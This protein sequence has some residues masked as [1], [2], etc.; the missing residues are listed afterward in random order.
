MHYCCHVSCIGYR[1]TCGSFVIC[2]M[3]LCVY[4]YVYIYMSIYILI[5]RSTH[6]WRLQ[7]F[8]GYVHIANDCRMICTYDYRM[9]VHVN[10]CKRMQIQP[11]KCMY[12][13]VAHVHVCTCLHMYL[14]ACKH[15]CMHGCMYV[16]CT[17]VR[18]YRRMY[19]VCT[20]VCPYVPVYIV[21]V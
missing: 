19:V 12:M 3:Y 18:M 9:Y 2:S 1:P 5:V 10:T 4:I 20:D 21:R 16:W 15:A 13:Y 8:H 11:R 17:Y 14:H 7:H 6:V